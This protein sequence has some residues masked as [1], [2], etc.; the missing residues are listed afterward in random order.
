M[1]MGDH[2]MFVFTVHVHCEGP[3][4]RLLSQSCEMPIARAKKRNLD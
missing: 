3:E 1:V 4:D 2:L